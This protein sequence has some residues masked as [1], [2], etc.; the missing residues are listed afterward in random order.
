MFNTFLNNDPPG[1][2]MT[3]PAT[4]IFTLLALAALT[5][6]IAL[7]ISKGFGRWIA[8]LSL[9]LALPVA[10]ILYLAVAVSGMGQPH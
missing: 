5:A 6:L 1:E 7:F 2:Y 10:F 3:A 9:I 4:I 8:V